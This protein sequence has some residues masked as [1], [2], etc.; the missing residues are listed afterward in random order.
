MKDIDFKISFNISEAGS[1]CHLRPGDIDGDG[2]LELVFAKPASVS[3]T[4]YFASAVAGLTAYSIEGELLWQV[5]D[6]T[7]DEKGSGDDLPLQVYDIDKDGKNEVI[8]VMDGNLLILDGKT[9]EVKKQIPLPDPNIGGSIIIADLEGTGYAQNIIIKNKLS[10]LWALDVNLNILWDAEG[11]I[12]LAP[13][14]YDINGDGKDEIIAGYNVFSSTGELLWKAEGVSHAVSSAVA[15]LHNSDEPVVIMYG[16]S[17]WAYS[18][19]GQLLWE[20]PEAAENIV[21][22]SFRDH[23]ESEEIFI[24]DNMALF[25]SNGHFLY[26]KNENVYL[27]APCYNFDG[28]GNIYIVGHRQEDIVTTVYDGYMRAV[29]TLPTFGNIAC[30]D[31]LGD[32]KSQILIYNNDTLDI[33]SDSPVDFSQP[34]RPYMRPQPKQYYNISR[35]N[36]LPPSQI[37]SGYLAEDFAAQNIMKW[38]STYSSINM[39]NSFAKTSRSEFVL[40]LATLLNLK[41]EFTENFADVSKEETCYNAVGTFRAL[42]IVSSEDNMF[43]P[44][45]PITVSEANKILD[46]LSIPINFNFDANYEISKQDMAKLIINIS[47]SN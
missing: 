44:D 28:T 4:R 17:V 46:N 29:Y 10:H 2:R 43:S 42:G 14:A 3:D 5:G 37:Q 34:Q 47:S 33:Y 45:S 30:F 23:I 6:V 18:K 31:I 32:G 26:Q 16:P 27:P 15:C 21:L 9:A 41:E 36:T 22:G 13:V 12:G 1:F 19:E 20:I 8:A 40:L 35:F 25:D 39:Y 38:A 11:N 24:L 7:G